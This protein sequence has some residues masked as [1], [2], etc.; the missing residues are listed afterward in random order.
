MAN[1]KICNYC[2]AALTILVGVLIARAALGYGIAMTF[3][4]PGPG[5]WPFVLGSLLGVIGALIVLDTVVHSRKFTATK[6]ILNDAGCVRAYIMMA[7]AVLYL[8]LLVILGF[9]ISSFIFLIGG[10][11]ILGMRNLKLAVAVSLL[12]LAGVYVLFSYL[13]H[14]QLPLP[15]FFD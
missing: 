6:V 11:W 12:F 10:M 7:A 2:V 3:F 4:G 1:M 9:Y 13:L 5:V 15:I 8:V 14:I